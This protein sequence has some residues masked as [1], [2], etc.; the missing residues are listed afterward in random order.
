MFLLWQSEEEENLNS[1]KHSCFTRYREDGTIFQVY[2]AVVGVHQ[3]ARVMFS[4]EGTFEVGLDI[5]DEW[6]PFGTK[7]DREEPYVEE[8]V[9]I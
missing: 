2:L 1:D 4:Q 9:E 6:L 7:Y 5:I 3:L 8:Y